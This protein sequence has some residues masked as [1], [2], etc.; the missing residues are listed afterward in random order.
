MNYPLLSHSPIF[1]IQFDIPSTPSAGAFCS[2]AM[3]SS[4]VTV[5][6]DGQGTAGNPQ[7]GE[8]DGW[9]KK[10][11]TYCKAWWLLY[12]EKSYYGDSMR[13]LYINRWFP[14]GP[15]P[16]FQRKA[17]NYEPFSAFFPRL[18]CFFPLRE[19]Y[20][21]F[22]HSPPSCYDFGL[23]KFPLWNSHTS[24][25]W[26]TANSIFHPFQVPVGPIVLI[27]SM[28]MAKITIFGGPWIPHLSIL[29]PFPTVAC[30]PIFRP[31][32][33]I[34]AAVRTAPRRYGSH[35]WCQRDSPP[36]RWWSPAAPASS[37]SRGSSNARGA[38][39]KCRVFLTDICWYHMY[40]YVYVLYIYKHI[41]ITYINMIYDIY[42]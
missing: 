21:I 10:T 5:P 37:P 38:Q 9:R 8:S 15:F 16:I 13:F 33:A 14:W 40:T 6:P 41:Y 3:N 34:S 1:F 25:S 29:C 12:I 17:M 32:S 4:G 19:P 26:K 28:K 18:S 39:R 2:P 7:R 35:P 11:K 24:V 31:V 36:P 20:C 30:S 42:I 27:L 22:D 23:S